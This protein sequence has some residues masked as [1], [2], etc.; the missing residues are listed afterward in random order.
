M[1][2]SVL[3]PL[4]LFPL[5]VALGAAADRPQQVHLAVAAGCHPEGLRI[6]AEA[7]W[8][9]E[10]RRLILLD[11]G[12]VPGDRPGDRVYAGV[13]TGEVVRTLP[14]RLYV[15]AD[16]IELTEVAASAETVALGSDRLVWALECEPALRARR[17]AA[18]MPVR[19]MEMAETT[20]VAATLAWVGLALTY[21]AWLLQP[22]RLRPRGGA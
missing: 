13:W 11:D 16:A 17:V 9:D 20:G 10:T 1:V 14:V 19:S 4:V 6:E 22:Q 3:F 8:L 15:S 12:S 18:A 2:D 7:Q 21:V 5:F